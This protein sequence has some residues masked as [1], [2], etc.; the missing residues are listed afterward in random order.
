MTTRTRKP[1]IAPMV[2][3]ATRPESVLSL[4]GTTICAVG[5]GFEVERAKDTA[6]GVVAVVKAPRL[7][8]LV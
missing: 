8:A 7:T 5:E 4:R 3:P 6:V 2:A 1:K